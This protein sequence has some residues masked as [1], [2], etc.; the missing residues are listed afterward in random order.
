MASSYRLHTPRA[1]DVLRYLI[2]RRD[3]VVEKT[4]LFERVWKEKFVTDNA[5]T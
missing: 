3:R 4:E 2:E 5:L 1:F